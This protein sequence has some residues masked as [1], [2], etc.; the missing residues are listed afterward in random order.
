METDMGTE[1]LASLA[2]VA[3]D[4]HGDYDSLFFNGS[5]HSSGSLAER[6]ARFATGLAE[7]GLRPGDRLLVLMANC[8]EVSI[9]YTAAWQAGAVVTPLIFLVSEEELRAALNDSGAVG[10][11]T[12]AECLP[13]VT[14]AVAGAAEAKFIVCVDR[15]P[16]VTATVTVADFAQVVTSSPP[17]SI[18]SRAAPPGGPRACRLPTLACSGAGRPSTKSTPPHRLTSYH[19]PSH[20]R[21]A[22]WCCAQACIA[23]NRAGAS[24]CAGST[25]RA[26]CGWLKSTA[27]KKELSCPR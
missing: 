17:G 25:Q 26:G 6:A 18:V 13:K 3:L 1:N 2:E 27:C 21:T 11:V 15:P 24:S 23:P 9:T 5:W 14:A 22:C 10:V 8:P 7:L 4:R 16:D 19:S 12:T 20:T